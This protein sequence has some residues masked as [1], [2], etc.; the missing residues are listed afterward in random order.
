MR[1]N[2]SN[3]TKEEASVKIAE[4]NKQRNCPVCGARRNRIA[5]LSRHSEG[6]VTFLRDNNFRLGQDSCILCV[7]KHLADAKR[8]IEKQ[9]QEIEGVKIE[10]QRLAA[11]GNLRE[12]TDESTEFKQ[13]HDLLAIQERQYRY[14]DKD[15]DWEKIAA[16]ILEV[17][18]KIQEEDQE[19]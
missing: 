16:V 7:E 10:L 8:A 3:I 6:L 19:K 13:L 15:P 11:I 18:A 17:K 4:L 1:K 14:N 5:E 12:A 9:R 2:L